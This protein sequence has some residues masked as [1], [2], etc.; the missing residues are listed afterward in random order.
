MSKNNV[1]TRAGDINRIPAGSLALLMSG[2]K[3][4]QVVAQPQ[5]SNELQS[6]RDSKAAR[7]LEHLGA[8]RN[9]ASA[10]AQRTSVPT[11][12]AAQGTR[13]ADGAWT[14][15]AVAAAWDR[16]DVARAVAEIEDAAAALRWQDMDQANRFSARAARYAAPVNNS[17]EVERLRQPRLWLGVGSMWASIAAATVGMLGGLAL[18][19]R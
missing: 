16:Q 19:M 9:S 13:D 5:R 4:T 8:V 17:W 14:F 6:R 1:N 12:G 3:A 15:A 11:R 2:A 7:E 18:L 10:G